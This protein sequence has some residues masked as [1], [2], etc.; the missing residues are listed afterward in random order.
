[1]I[2]RRK[3]PA[4]GVATTQANRVWTAGLVASALISAA[5]MTGLCGVRI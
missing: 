4:H 1:M 3:D 5:I 2:A